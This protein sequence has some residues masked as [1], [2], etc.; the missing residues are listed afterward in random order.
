MRFPNV[1][2]QLKGAAGSAK[3]LSMR[4]AARWPAASW[5][6]SRLQGPVLGRCSD[7]LLIAMRAPHWQGFLPCCTPGCS[8]LRRP[9]FSASPGS[10]QCTHSA[11]KPQINADQRP[12]SIRRPSGSHAAAELRWPSDTGSCGGAIAGSDQPP[13]P[14]W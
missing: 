1:S 6:R 7:R 11:L 14:V 3:A 10:S 4:G 12:A 2:M 5:R 8:R 13:L 9:V